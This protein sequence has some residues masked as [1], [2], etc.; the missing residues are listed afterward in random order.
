VLPANAATFLAGN[1]TISVGNTVANIT[2]NS[3]QFSVMNATSNVVITPSSLYIGNSIANASMNTS[4]MFVGNAT[5]S[6]TVNSTSFS[7]TSNNALFLG[8]VAA[9][10]IPTNTYLQTV[11]GAGNPGFYRLVGSCGGGNTITYTAESITMANTTGGLV[12]VNN[13]N[14]TANIFVTGAGGC[15]AQFTYYKTAGT[16]IYTYT[17]GGGVAAS[18]T[19]FFGQVDTE[20]FVYAWAIAVNSS[21]SALMLSNSS[22]APT[23]PGSYTYKLLIGVVQ[24]LYTENF[25]DPSYDNYLIGPAGFRQ[26]GTTWRRTGSYSQKWF[27]NTRLMNSYTTWTSFVLLASAGANASLTGASNTAR[28][29]FIPS[30]GTNDIKSLHGT[31]QTA[32]VSG[33]YA[34]ISEYATGTD[35]S[36]SSTTGY[37]GSAGDGIFQFE[38]FLQSNSIYYLG[39]GDNGRINFTG[40]DLNI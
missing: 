24:L 29:S 32:G 22:T 26:V 11:I 7:G 5:V 39:T 36:G 19:T 4:S 2:A 23:M 34:F 3:I 13:F 10:N 16:P 21:S 31:F 9:T 8:G 37:G 17:Y 18:I 27:A 38:A 15:D 14:Q 6:I 20:P 35:K 33:R 1:G 25:V 28:I 40:F 30:G 12:R